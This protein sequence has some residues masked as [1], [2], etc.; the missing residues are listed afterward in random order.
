MVVGEGAVLCGAE[1]RDG[2]GRGRVLADLAE[3]EGVVEWAV[4]S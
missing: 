4:E 1:L 3:W 2:G